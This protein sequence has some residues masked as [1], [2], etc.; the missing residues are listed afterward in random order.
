MS[1][2]SA[3]THTINVGEWTNVA[4]AVAVRWIIVV[5]IS[6]VVSSISTCSLSDG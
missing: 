4:A 1:T 6:V 3:T 2:T 5:T